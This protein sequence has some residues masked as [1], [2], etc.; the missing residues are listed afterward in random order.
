[1]G[2]SRAVR[3]GSH[4][5]VSGCVGLEVDGRFD[6]DLARQTARCMERIAD[7]L[8]AF[9]LALH[10]IVRLRIY[11]TRIAEWRAIASVVGPLMADSRPANLLVGVSALVDPEALIEI[12]ADAWIP[13]AKAVGATP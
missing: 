3:A 8:G 7:A 1:M 4:V 10:D 6:A 12:E 2:Y 9:G 11:T 13:T 5:H